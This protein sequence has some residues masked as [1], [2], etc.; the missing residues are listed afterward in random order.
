ML[1]L[2]FLFLPDVEVLTV[3]GDQHQATL[4]VNL[5]LDDLGVPQVAVVL[6][7]QVLVLKK[8]LL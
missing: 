7:K 1:H 4:S 5:M 2:P 6:S 3:A 8:H